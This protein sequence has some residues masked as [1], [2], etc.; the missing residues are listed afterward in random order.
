MTQA[1]SWEVATKENKWQGRNCSRFRNEEV[2]K[3]YTAALGELDPVKR[4]ANFIRMNEIVVGPEVGVIIP[5][6]YR[7]RAH[8]RSKTLRADISGWDS[9]TWAIARWYREA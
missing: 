7:P 4:A 8:S 3:L 2:D 6:V 1:V 5:V 9:D